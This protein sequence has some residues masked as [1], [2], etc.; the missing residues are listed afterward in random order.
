MNSNVY[1]KELPSDKENFRIPL[2]FLVIIALFRV[3]NL[4]HP[5]D[6]ARHLGGIVGSFFQPLVTGYLS[7]FC[8]RRARYNRS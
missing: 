2:L 3:S 5:T 7:W 4:P 1:V 8:F 6:M